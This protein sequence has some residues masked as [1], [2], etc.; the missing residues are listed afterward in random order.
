MRVLDRKLLRDAIRLW[1]Q[2]LAIALVL[3]SGVGTL[4]LSMGVY[5]SLDETLRAYYERHRFGH[6]FASATR[7]PRSL[8]PAIRALDGVASVDVRASGAAI[9]DLPGLREPASAVLLGLPEN[10]A[11]DDAAN[12]GLN[13]VYLKSGHLPEPGRGNQIA[14]N[15]AFA[16]ANDLE[17]GDTLSAV[18]NG[19]WTEFRIS[20]IVLSPDTIYTLGPGDLIP[21]DRRFGAFWMP[22][23]EVQVIYDLEGAFNQM[24]VLLQHGADET[25]V[26]EAIDRLLKPYGGTAAHGRDNHPSHAFVDAELSELRGMMVVLPPVF[27]LVTAFLVHMILS[28]LIALEREQI[29][30]LKAVGYGRWTIAA[31]YLK[32]VMIIAALGIVLGTAAGAWLGYELTGLFARFYHFPIL[33]FRLSPEV[34]L[35]AAAVAVVAS[36]GGA[37]GAVLRVV[38]LQPVVAMSP[39]APP[40]FRRTRLLPPGMDRLFSESTV[41]V[42]RHL[43]RTPTRS[44]LTMVGVSFSVAVMITS[45]FGLDSVDK[46]IDVTFHQSE[47]QHAS[48]S[49][50]EP[51][52]W[53]AVNAVRRLPGVLR[54][55]PFRSVS[56][57]LHHGHRNRRVAVQG[58]P[59][60]ADL[61]RVLNTAL[62]PVELPPVGIAIT[63]KLAEV[64][65]ARAGDPVRLEFLGRE[66]GVH[67]M[68]ISKVI[69][70]YF[71]LGAY[72]PLES[73]HRLLGED[74]LVSGINLMLDDNRLDAFY[75]EVKATPSIHAISLLR[76]AMQRF[77]ETIGENIGIMVTTF[78]TLGMVIAFGVCYNSARVQLS[79]RAR[80]LASL[81]VLGFS[82]WEVSRI[83]LKEMG[84]LALAGIPL[85]WFTGYWLAWLASRGMQS[86]LYQVPFLVE[87]ATFARATM[88]VLVA[89]ILSGAIVWR[90]VRHLD[91]IRVLKT[92]E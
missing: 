55:E 80:E 12:R 8:L 11:G 89:V 67:E 92:R 27:L 64:L 20:A 39:P 69:Q 1:A 42:T 33:I 65:H 91:L 9:L 76:R 49:F 81:R 57:R 31:H 22:D 17:P 68:K 50:H 78:S 88:V 52:T 18:A 15:E 75:R 2:G 6:I 36:A 24:A 3:A 46:M 58:K 32:L 41:M 84:F 10:G 62:E 4:I 40:V 56:A 16:N 77:R 61:S 79:E 48:I 83:L 13:R 23:S 60:D 71:G 59:D 70:G 14:I 90:R 34:F 7:A 19:R 35:V 74:Q 72:M 37:L 26:I 51:N 5:Q 73:L 63:E 43:L 44:L 87:P 53:R 28:R 66:Q 85:G 45:M 86:E 82:R 54:A 30:L 47:R 38:Q 21:D 29:G 25:P